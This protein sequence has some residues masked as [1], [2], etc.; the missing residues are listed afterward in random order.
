MRR[1]RLLRAAHV[2]VRDAGWATYSLDEHGS[3]RRSARRKPHAPGSACGVPPPQG[4]RVG[5]AFGSKRACACAGASAVIAGTAEEPDAAAQAASFIAAFKSAY[6]D[7][8][9][10][11]VEVACR[12][13]ISQA[14]AE[15][16]FLFVYL[17]ASEHEVRWAPRAPACMHARA[18]A[19]PWP[20][21]PCHHGPRQAAVRGWLLLTS[22]HVA[23]S[24]IAL[25]GAPTARIRRSAG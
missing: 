24:R 23:R 8:H 17:H 11:F 14:R 12:A 7:R 20:W 3:S 22:Q 1:F 15:H 2:A 6:G 5:G 13:A 18:H 4:R 9:P 21:C 10:R 16:K 19:L 25:R